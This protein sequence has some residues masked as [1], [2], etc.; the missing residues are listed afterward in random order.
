MCQGSIHHTVQL[1]D[2]PGQVWCAHGKSACEKAE[3]GEFQSEDWLKLQSNPF[4][5]KLDK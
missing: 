2:V 4:F 5:D 3:A 1:C